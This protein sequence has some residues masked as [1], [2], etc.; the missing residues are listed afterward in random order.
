M[1]EDGSPADYSV[2][3]IPYKPKHH[4]PIQL[5]GFENED[6]TMIMGYPG[7]TNR[8]LTSFGVKEALEITYPEIIDI[9]TKKLEIMKSEMNSSKKVKLQYACP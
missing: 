7:R 3:N 6:F 8:Y 1:G 2:D 9:R 5:A 4:L